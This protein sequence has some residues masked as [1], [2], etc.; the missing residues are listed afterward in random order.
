MPGL[1]A[2]V[3]LCPEAPRIRVM[4][5]VEF[6]HCAPCLCSCPATLPRVP[7]H[8]TPVLARLARVDLYL[9]RVLRLLSQQA[10][11]RSPLTL[12]RLP[13]R[14]HPF[15]QLLWISAEPKIFLHLSPNSER[16]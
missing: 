2:W 12:S 14:A 13:A 1:R 8:G 5:T 16:V 15:P 10:G 7:L 4:R 9:A 6:Q 11:W 3:V